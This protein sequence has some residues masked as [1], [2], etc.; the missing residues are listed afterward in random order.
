M[1]LATLRKRAA[2]LPATWSGSSEPR[3]VSLDEALALLAIA[4]AAAALRPDDLHH[5]PL[6][7]IDYP[8][9]SPEGRVRAFETALAALEA[10]P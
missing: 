6:P 1:T 9:G 7:G 8:P 10:L 2:A 5:A 3:L 4:A